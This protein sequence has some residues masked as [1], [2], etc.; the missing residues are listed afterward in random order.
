MNG[1]I[2]PAYAFMEWTGKK[3]SIFKKKPD[4]LFALQ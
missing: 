3:I 4:A 1:A 2:F